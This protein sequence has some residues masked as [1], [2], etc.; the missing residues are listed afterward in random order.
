MV[1]PPP[2]QSNEKISV[3][4]VTR[5]VKDKEQPRGLKRGWK[6]LQR[7]NEQYPDIVLHD[8]NIG[9]KRRQRLAETIELF[10]FIERQ[11]LI[12]SSPVIVAAKLIIVVLDQHER[13]IYEPIGFHHGFKRAGLE[14]F[15]LTIRSISHSHLGK[16]CPPRRL[17][18]QTTEMDKRSNEWKGLVSEAKAVELFHIWMSI[19][20]IFLSF[21]PANEN[22]DGK[23]RE[24]YLSLSLILQ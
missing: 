22:S 16:R 11:Q 23:G 3:H 1:H 10:H 24:A 9:K 12:K 21:C 4:K 8:V 15:H 18:G 17:T 13:H 19:C 7:L 20:C 5:A 14:F 6:N 2:C